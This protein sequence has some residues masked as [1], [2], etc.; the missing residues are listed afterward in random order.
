MRM[1]MISGPPAKPN[2]TGTGMPG[3]AKGNEPKISPRK[4]PTK[5]VAI[6]GAFRRRTEFPIWLAT[7]STA[8][9]G[10]T[11]MILSPTCRGRLAEAKRSMPCR[12]RRVTL[13]PC[14]LEKCMDASVLPFTLGLVMRIRLD[15]NG[16]S[17]CSKSMSSFG[18]MKAM[19][20]SWSAS[21][22]TMSIW[23]PTW[24]MVSRFGMQS[25]PSW[26]RRDT[27]K[28]RFR[29]SC[30]CSSVLPSRYLFVT[31]RCILYGFLLVLVSSMAFNCSSSFS[32]LILHAYLI[33]IVAPMMPKTPRG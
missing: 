6:F 11:T 28:S 9:S 10:P 5:I 15:T 14:T 7:R 27:T 20:A 26:T 4:T 8:S 30:T 31:S 25:S 16:W 17:C 19:I 22:Q 3:M 29:K 33:N 32:N 13:T 1:A 18:P 12:V 21:A 23:S 24:K 2:F